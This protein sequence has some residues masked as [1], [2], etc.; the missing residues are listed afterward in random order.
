MSVDP[1]APLCL[2]PL[3]LSRLPRVSLPAGTV[4]AHFHVFAAGA[5]LNTPR[6]YTPQILT[7][8]DWTTYADALGMARGVLVQP[9]VYGT[10]NSVLLAALTQAPERLRGVVVISP[11]TKDA[12]IARLD[13]MGVRGIRINLR[14]KAGIGLDALEA[15]A[16]RIRP[17]GWHVVFQV[18][19]DAIAS[20]A[21]LAAR[22]ELVGIVDHLAFMP[23]DPVGPALDALHRALDS[24]RIYTKISAPYRLGDRPDHAGYRQAV[25]SLVDNHTNRVLWG[26][27]WPHTELFDT[28][29]EDADLIELSLDVVAP[30]ARELVFVRNAEAIYWSR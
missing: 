25:R 19:P 13:Q 26:S 10:D 4:D 18:G 16:P 3:P 12:E 28:M 1:D 21:E 8:D 11:D 27:D 24:G 29:Q 5:P 30:E 15:L 6:S 23:L 7:L 20:V 17:L 22:H 2:P 14:N 9:S